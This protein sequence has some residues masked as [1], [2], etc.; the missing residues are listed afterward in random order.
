MVLKKL[1]RLYFSF[2]GEAIVKTLKSG[3]L[4]EVI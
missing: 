2:S 3:E 4:I 1:A